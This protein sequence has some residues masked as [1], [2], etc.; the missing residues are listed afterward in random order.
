[1]NDFSGRIKRDEWK[2]P[3]GDLRTVAVALYTEQYMDVSDISERHRGCL[4][5]F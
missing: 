4:W 2:P 1:M 3:K 5:D